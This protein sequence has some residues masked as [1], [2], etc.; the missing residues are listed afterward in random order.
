MENYINTMEIRRESYNKVNKGSQYE[1]ILLCFNGNEMSAWDISEKTG[2]LITSVRARL[3]ELRK[4]GTVII[5]KA[6]TYTPTK[7]KVSFFKKL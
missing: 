7:R 6:E 4:K 1:K 3:N 2:L 5:T